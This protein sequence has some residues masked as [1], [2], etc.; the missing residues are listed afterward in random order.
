MSKRDR[1]SHKAS[2]RTVKSRKAVMSNDIVEV[3]DSLEPKFGLGLFAK[4]PLK[5]GEFVASMYGE[6]MT[7]KEYESLPE[8]LQG[9]AIFFNPKKAY[10]LFRKNGGYFDD[11]EISDFYSIFARV[12]DID[13]EN[14][15]LLDKYKQM[16]DDDFVDETDVHQI[17]TY[18]S[19][20]LS[21]LNLF[22]ELVLD[23]TNVESF[24]K[25]ANDPRGDRLRRK[26]NARMR[27]TR[28]GTGFEL[29]ATKNIDAGD[30]ILIDYGDEYFK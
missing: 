4:V 1:K 9:K 21:L 20:L 5:K 25:Y 15:E 19:R 2:S 29:I 22:P 18:L 10:S 12:D 6:L 27:E 28:D 3:K 14:R 16:S 23:V 24:A 7:I 26:A 30:E 8:H 17:D 13:I 11:E